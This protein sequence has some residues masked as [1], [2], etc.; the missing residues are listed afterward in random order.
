MIK[1]F[2]LTFVLL[3]IFSFV[4]RVILSE[5]HP[6]ILKQKLFKITPHIIDTLLLLSG[7]ALV[8]QGGWLYANYGWIIA[9]IA[10]LFGYIGLGVVVMHNRGTIRWLAFIGAMACF[11][12]IGIVAVTKNALFFL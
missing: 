9:K 1:M 11:V 2:H 3:S 6:A 4:G 7:I 5:T 10:A 12:Y 8:F